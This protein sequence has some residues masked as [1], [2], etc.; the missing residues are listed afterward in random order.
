MPKKFFK[1]FVPSAQDMKKKKTYRFLGKWLH[2]SAIWH[3]NRRSVAGAF[4]IGLFF[5][6]FPIPSQI[7]Y[8]SITAV[9]FRVNLPISASLVWITNPITIPPLFY[10]AYRLGCFLLGEDASMQGF[11]M[12]IEWFTNSFGQIWQPLMVGSLSLGVISGALGYILIHLMWRLHIM[13][14]WKN[15]K[16]KH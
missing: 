10:S 16:N 9:Y 4:A 2:D 8:S 15:R 12:S 7:V 13:I 5:A 11:E 14:R 3:F 6:W 1:K